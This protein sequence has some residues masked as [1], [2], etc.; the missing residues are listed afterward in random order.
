MK[1]YRPKLQ[2]ILTPTDKAVEIAGWVTLSLFWCY[3]LLSYKTLPEVIPTHFGAGGKA[4]SFGEKSSVFG[5]PVIA[6]VLYIGLTLLNRFPHLYNFAVELNPE[7]ALRQ[8]TIA[9]RMI[10]WLKLGVV[11]L[12]AVIAYST[13]AVANTKNPQLSEWFFPI[14]MAIIFGIVGYFLTKS[15]SKA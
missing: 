9:T 11:V 15:I 3:I 4:D 13:I 14:T 10:R 6:T 8:Y 2:P 12:F 1:P 5:L 7:N